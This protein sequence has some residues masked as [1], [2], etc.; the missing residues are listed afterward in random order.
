M[1]SKKAAASADLKTAELA[2]KKNKWKLLG[3]QKMLILMSV[4]FDP[5]VTSFCIIRNFV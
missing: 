2:N 1:K 4:P 5:Y 3:K